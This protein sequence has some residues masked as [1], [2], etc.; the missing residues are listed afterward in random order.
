MKLR[1]IWPGKTRKQY[2]KEAIEDYTARIAKF[3]PLEIIETSEESRTD[4]QRAVRIRRE[5]E[6]LR[7]RK[8]SPLTVILDSTGKTMSSEEF[9]R[10]LEK[11]QSDI[12]FILGGPAGFEAS[13]SDLRFSFGPVTLPHELARVVLLEQIYRALTIMHHFPYHK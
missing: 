5:S 6:S 4:R 9:A 10:W 2:Y 12:D 13:Y 3:L 8:R 7:A 1:I 11:Q